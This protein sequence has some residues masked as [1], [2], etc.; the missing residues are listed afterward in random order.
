MTC[1]LSKKQETARS[2]PDP[3]PPLEG[4]VWERDY[5][6]ALGWLYI[7]K[8]LQ[9]YLFLFNSILQ[10]LYYILGLGTILIE[11]DKT[12]TAIRLTLWCHNLP[13]IFGGESLDYYIRLAALKQVVAYAS[14]STYYRPRPYR[15]STMHPKIPSLHAQ[16]GLRRLT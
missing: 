10:L 11:Y 8:V 4:G 16:L 1:Q 12:G 15:L 14:T 9:W 6:L 2:A 13:K 3:F 5:M 7:A